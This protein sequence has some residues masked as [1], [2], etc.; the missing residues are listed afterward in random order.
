[1]V[2]RYHWGCAVGH[3]YTQ[4]ES[5]CHSHPCQPSATNDVLDD[6]TSD[7]VVDSEHIQFAGGIVDAELLLHAQDDD[8]W[9]DTDDEDMDRGGVH[10]G[11]VSEDEFVASA[12]E[13]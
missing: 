4:T 2:M 12:D 9:D 8:I 13:M 11:G 3:T 5:A 6:Q 10:D 1:M 7:D